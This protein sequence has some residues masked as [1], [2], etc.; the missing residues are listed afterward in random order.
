MTWSWRLKEEQEFASREGEGRPRWE[1]SRGEGL[2]E[3]E[4]GHP[5][6]FNPHLPL[7]TPDES[8]LPLRGS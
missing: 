2:E 3:G 6:S 7:G 5:C 8:E 4:Q 1:K